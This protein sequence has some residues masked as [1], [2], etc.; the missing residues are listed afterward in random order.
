MEKMARVS[1][2]A[3]AAPMAGTRSAVPAEVDVGNIVSGDKGSKAA[4]R[5]RVG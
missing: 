1:S 4:M 3:A 2:A 5:V